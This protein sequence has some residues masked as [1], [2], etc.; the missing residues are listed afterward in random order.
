[1]KGGV[2][3]ESMGYFGILAFCFV[4][5]LMGL[6]KKVKHLQRKVKQLSK[7]LEGDKAMSKVLKELIGKKCSIYTDA[8]GNVG[9][10]VD[11][12]EEWVKLEM[13]G[14]KGKSTIKIFPIESISGIEI[15]E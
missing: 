2:F 7:R 1:M 11:V 14:R 15:K 6:P 10:V 3:V 8:F 5:S 4:L 12:D 13:E 9:K